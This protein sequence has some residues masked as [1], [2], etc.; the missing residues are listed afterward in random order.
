[1]VAKYIFTS[2]VWIPCESNIDTK[3]GTVTWKA[4]LIAESIAVDVKSFVPCEVNEKTMDTNIRTLVS[5][6]VGNYPKCFITGEIT[7]KTQQAAILAYVNA[8]PA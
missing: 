1:M 6:S 4:A 7:E 2:K 8:I 5:M 3:S